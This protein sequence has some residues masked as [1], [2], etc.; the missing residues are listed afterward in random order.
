VFVVFLQ[1]FVS[2]QVIKDFN[3]FRQEKKNQP[4]SRDKDMTVEQ[5]LNWRLSSSANLAKE[6]LRDAN[7]D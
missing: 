7:D 6:K 4:T 5:M 2:E 1:L 3:I